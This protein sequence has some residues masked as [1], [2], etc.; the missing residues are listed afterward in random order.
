MEKEHYFSCI[1][2]QNI[3]SAVFVTRSGLQTINYEKSDIEMS[4]VMND[5]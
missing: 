1:R 3:I 4:L 5:K 2:D